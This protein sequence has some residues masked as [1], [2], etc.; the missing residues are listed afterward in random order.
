MRLDWLTQQYLG[1]DQRLFEST[2]SAASILIMFEGACKTFN[3][4]D[5]LRSDEEMANN[6]IYREQL[7]NRIH[8]D[9]AMLIQDWYPQLHNLSPVLSSPCWFLPSSLADLCEP[10]RICRWKQVLHR[11]SGNHLADG[12]LE[13]WRFAMLRDVAI[14]RSHLRVVLHSFGEAEIVYD[15]PGCHPNPLAPTRW[16]HAQNSLPSRGRLCR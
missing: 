13:E 12:G 16:G 15:V 11:R 4:R 7:R 14:Q 2:L 1:L 5:A 10:R 3:L 9:A 6:V 8:N